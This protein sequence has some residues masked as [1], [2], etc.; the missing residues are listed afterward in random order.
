MQSSNPNHKTIFTK[1]RKNLFY[2]R[3]RFHG[4]NEMHK[5]TIH[6]DRE[7]QSTMVVALKDLW[8]VDWK[9]A[10]AALGG[11][12]F[13]RFIN[14]QVTEWAENN[15]PIWAHIRLC[16]GFFYFFLPSILEG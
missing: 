5:K 3:N 6:A 16:G 10:A 8:V 11:F 2:F 12:L 4:N 7:R 14:L 15:N 1:T 13:F 9:E